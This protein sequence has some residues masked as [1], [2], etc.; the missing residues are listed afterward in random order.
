MKISIVTISFNQYEFLGQCINSVLSQ[1]ESLSKAGVELEYIVVDP[2]S[3]D[4]SRELITS[5]GNEIITVF[6]KDSGPSDG[7]NK[8]FFNATG[9]IFAYINADDFFL[10]G[11]LCEAINVFKANDCD[12]FYGH[13]WI[14]DEQGKKVHRCL[15]H[16][17]SLKQYA[18]GN[19][20]IMQQSTFFKKSAFEKARG[21]NAENKVCW[22]GELIVDM[23]LNGAKSVRVNKFLSSFRVYGSS[24]SGSGNYLEASRKE[25][26]R[27]ANKINRICGFDC[28]ENTIKE[29]LIIRLS[30]PYYLIIRIIDQIQY[31]KRAI[32]S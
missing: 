9:D 1:R 29:K 19:S 20:V 15:S 25:H 17:F 21:F 3:T 7:L 13:G 23:V 18:L 12:I 27:I 11:A 26:V 22:D 10:E 5:Y 16:K 14:V 4:G 8:G 24:I 30:D 28:K 31:G 32:P 2:G 6:E